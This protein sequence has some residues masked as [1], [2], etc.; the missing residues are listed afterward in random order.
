MDPISIFGLTAT[1]VSISLQLGSSIQRLADLKS[2]VSSANLIVHSLIRRLSVIQYAIKDIRAWDDD[3]KTP[4]PSS[5]EFKDALTVSL[6][7]C[8]T[9]L[10]SLNEQISQIYANGELTKWQKGKFVWK[11]TL[12]KDYLG[13]LDGEIQALNLLLNSHQCRTISDQSRLLHSRQSRHILN[14]VKE[15]TASLRAIFR[16]GDSTSTARSSLAESVSNQTSFS[17]DHDLFSSLV[18]QRR[19]QQLKPA[20]LEAR[21]Q[22]QKQE[23]NDEGRTASLAPDLNDTGDNDTI[24]N[25]TTI[26]SNSGDTHEFR[27]PPIFQGEDLAYQF[28]QILSQDPLEDKTHAV[29]EP[30]VESLQS[31]NREVL[32]AHDEASTSHKQDELTLLPA[33]SDLAGTAISDNRRIMQVRREYEYNEYDKP[34]LNDPVIDTSPNNDRVECPS[35]QR[36][37]TGGHKFAQNTTEKSHSHEE[38]ENQS[39]GKGPA[40]DT[41]IVVQNP[42]RFSKGFDVSSENTPEKTL[43]NKSQFPEAI[44]PTARKRKSGQTLPLLPGGSWDPL[45]NS[46]SHK[47]DAVIA[48]HLDEENRNLSNFGIALFQEPSANSGSDLIDHSQA[49][50]SSTR[51]FQALSGKPSSDPSWAGKRWFS[52]LRAKY[53]P[54]KD[55]K[56]KTCK[57][58]GAEFNQ[59]TEDFESSER[60]K[61][62]FTGTIPFHNQPAG[63]WFPN[64]DRF[65]VT[66]FLSNNRWLSVAS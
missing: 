40:P 58:C 34:I 51:T 66:S 48:P 62:L 64:R 36:L 19:I 10:Q 42:K 56:L 55:E 45:G 7:G 8:N 28:Q 4:S 47:L 41:T 15:D 59:G 6:E 50:H 26:P 31:R 43:K 60:E 3:S 2:K 17:F 39:S 61:V 37:N 44:L 20:T 13:Y 18:Y 38:G 57:G 21:I 65:E 1:V 25:N 54:V 63:L 27:L 53:S 49:S 9:I 11:E 32:K 29:L 52:S 16:S 30:T 33:A 14:V 5:A 12:L 46:W 23:V 35:D 22:Q 24:N